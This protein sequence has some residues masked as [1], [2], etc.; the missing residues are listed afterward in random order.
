MISIYILDLKEFVSDTSNQTDHKSYED[1]IRH[2]HPENTR[3]GI[4]IDHR[5][6]RPP[7][8]SLCVCVCCHVRTIPDSHT[9]DI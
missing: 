1:W 4:F 3:D 5:K 7:R 9:D 2:C 8:C 6:F